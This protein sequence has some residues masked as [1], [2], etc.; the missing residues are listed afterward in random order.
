MFH[1]ATC[2]LALP[3]SSSRALRLRRLRTNEART[4]WKDATKRRAPS[5]IYADCLVLRSKLSAKGGGFAGL[6]QVAYNR[7]L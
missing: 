4:G 7:M 3:T 5:I 1:S 6:F 2:N